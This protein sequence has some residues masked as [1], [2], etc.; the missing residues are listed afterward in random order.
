MTSQ[1]D[2]VKVP[3]DRLAVVIG[4]NGKTKQKIE[5]KTGVDLSINTKDSRIEID[6][7]NADPVLGWKVKMVIKAIGR[8][9]TPQKA[10]KLLERRETFE[11]IKIT[12]YANTK[13]SIH[14]LKGRVIGSNGKSR[15]LLEEISKTDISI[16]GKTIGIIGKP[17]RVSPT[18]EAI[19]KILNGSPHGNAYK[20]LKD[21][22]PDEKEIS[23]VRKK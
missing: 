14:R 1:T 16:Y 21:A 8:G 17:E 7:K 22:I 4:E 3:E 13:D 9:F 23:Y 10:L 2:Y 15:K 12:E 5:E 20:Y 19:K 18:I 6:R 11:L